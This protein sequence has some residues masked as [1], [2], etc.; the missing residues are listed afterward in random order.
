M[1]GYDVVIAGFRLNAKEQPAKALERILSMSPEQARVCSKQFPHLA[2]SNAPREAAEA[3]RLQLD[4]AGARVS[5]APHQAGAPVANDIQR[6]AASPPPPARSVSLAAVEPLEVEP[7]RR[8]VVASSAKPRVS[9]PPASRP[10]ATPSRPAEEAS[11][12]GGYAL[13]DLALTAT[14]PLA[15]KPPAA[16]AASPVARPAP[17]V[18]NDFDMEEEFASGS[19]LDLDLGGGVGPNARV[20]L[21][22]P[23]AR[24][25]KK[26]EARAKAAA[27]AQDFTV[28]GGGRDLDDTF[29]PENQALASLELQTTRGAG[30]SAKGLH[31]GVT[32]ARRQR[33]APAQVTVKPAA[34]VSQ[35]RAAQGRRPW[36][37]VSFIAVLMA[38][39][40]GA[41]FLTPW[42]RAREQTPNAVA[43]AVPD[44][45]LALDG[46]TSIA[47]T[48]S[49][50]R[51]QRE[52]V[53]VPA[54]Q[55]VLQARERE[56]PV[57][58]SLEARFAERARRWTESGDTQVLRGM[59]L[60]L[61]ELFEHR[62]PQENAFVSLPG[63]EQPSAI[64][65][66]TLTLDHVA[67]RDASYAQN[68]YPVTARFA[69]A[70][71]G[72][73]VREVTYTGPL[74]VRD[75]D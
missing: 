61:S 56:G 1:A 65:K 63:K 52:G 25:G 59:E 32:P 68:V 50:R 34:V 28:G 4:E 54:H 7:S 57:L 35:P 62:A 45:V 26:A 13:G 24:P 30:N 10:S 67:P 17:S 18:K 21:S 70:L 53:L 36:L 37:Y 73:E 47:A 41:W 49:M 60:P 43:K 48:L 6:P 20:G 74:T 2:L 33:P 46:V 12:G 19:G 23:P 42:F 9:A 16:A 55:L 5:I 71:K 44:G 66:A 69:L 31:N 72:G 58:L 75:P 22:N 8:A 14:T 51:G 3:L 38:A 29:A 11:L 39:G 40:A 64:E 15:I 27:P